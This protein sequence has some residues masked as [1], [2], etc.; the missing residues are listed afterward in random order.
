MIHLINNPIKLL[1]AESRCILT[2]IL[3]E[4]VRMDGFKTLRT[5]SLVQYL[6]SQTGLH[7]Q[8][9]VAGP[10]ICR[11][12]DQGAKICTFAGALCAE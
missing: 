2:G 7:R 12:N 1:L 9:P 10:R 5:V 3:A 11:L 6:Y 8:Q 4:T